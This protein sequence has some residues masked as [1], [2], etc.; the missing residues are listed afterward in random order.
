MKLKTNL[1]F[2]GAVISLVAFLGEGRHQELWNGD[3]LIHFTL[4]LSVTIYATIFNVD[5]LIRSN[6]R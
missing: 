6:R 5:C 3:A 2:K 1:F 4:V